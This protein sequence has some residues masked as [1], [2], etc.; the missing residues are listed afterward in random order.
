MLLA[1]AGVF[2]A[3]WLLALLP[4]LLA[5]GRVSAHRA[6]TPCC[7]SRS[8]CWS[9]SMRSLD[10]SPARDRSRPRCRVW[11]WS[12]P[13]STR[14]SALGMFAA[15]SVFW[16]RWTHPGCSSRIEFSRLAGRRCAT[17]G[18]I[19]GAWPRS[20]IAV[21]VL[22]QWPSRRM[23]A[24]RLAAAVDVCGPH[25]GGVCLSLLVGHRT[26]RV[27]RDLIERQRRSVADAFCDAQARYA[28]SAGSQPVRPGLLRG[29]H[30]SQPA[31]AGLL[32]RRAPDA[33]GSR[34]CSSLAM[35]RPPR[36]HAGTG[37][38]PRLD[39][40]R[41]AEHRYRSTA[42]ACATATSSSR[43]PPGVYRMA[44]VGSSVVMGY[45]VRDDEVF[46]DCWKTRLN[47]T[48]AAG[49]SRWSS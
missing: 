23:Q 43:S 39:A 29:D 48:Q 33:S 8:A 44:L 38:D 27:R 25:R 32:W 11:S 13:R 40:A 42:G 15:V 34:T 49:Q 12:L 45:G 17:V 22:V 26:S 20:S 18:W 36:R 37:A 3:T 46:S 31:I 35:T 7:G 10:L 30:R 9:R 24:S 14:S 41:S 6:T 28:H 47:A 21:G 4:A 1:T 2:L 5:A 16:G 19:A